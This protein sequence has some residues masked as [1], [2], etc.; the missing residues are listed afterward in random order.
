MEG[1]LD[2]RGWLG[3]RAGWIAGEPLCG[4]RMDK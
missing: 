3:R 2:M 4:R 1:L